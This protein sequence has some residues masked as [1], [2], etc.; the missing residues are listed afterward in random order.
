MEKKKN[1]DESVLHV[2]F[3]VSSVWLDR[4][5]CRCPAGGALKSVRSLEWRE[6][7]PQ[8]SPDPSSPSGTEN[9]KRHLKS[10]KP[11]QD[12]RIS[13]L[14]T[15][16]SVPLCV[17]CSGCRWQRS[18]DWRDWSW[19]SFPVLPTETNPQSG[20]TQKDTRYLKHLPLN[21][22]VVVYMSLSPSRR[23]AGLK[24][25]LKVFK[26]VERI[27]GYLGDRLVGQVWEDLHG[28][29]VGFQLQAA[30]VQPVPKLGRLLGWDQNK[31]ADPQHHW[32]ESTW[33]CFLYMTWISLVSEPMINE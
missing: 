33:C 28:D 12:F 6:E 3:C 17:C 1:T 14:E 8:V 15:V 19:R 26:R 7:W 22:A 11:E 20:G 32:S 29:A 23:L 27:C 16:I 9:R 24:S 30:A 25:F 21:T 2:L 10:L 13:G 4:P 5:R 31:A 18:R